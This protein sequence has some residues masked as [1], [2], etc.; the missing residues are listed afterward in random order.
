MA[1]GNIPQD[2]IGEKRSRFIGR[3]FEKDTFFKFFLFFILI[4]FL[5]AGYV[6]LQRYRSSK[7]ASVA[8]TAAAVSENTSAA[9]SGSDANSGSLLQ[10][11]TNTG[12]DTAASELTNANYK[13]ENFRVGEMTIGGDTEFL[14]QDS[15][16]PLEIGSIRS[17]AYNEKNKQEVNLVLSWKTNKLAKSDV[18]YSKGVG[19]Q[20]KKMSEDDFSFNHSMVIPGLDQASTYVY[21]ITSGDR[22]GDVVRSDA[23]VVYTGSKTAS[24]FDL[25]SGAIGDVFGWAVKK[26]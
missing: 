21:T 5:V 10:T 2:F 15:P 4:A 26:N 9:K 7:T 3:I 22:S 6:L 13:S 20:E 23:H 24:L 11:S 19:Q 12:S 1:N 16:A 14:T 25:I 17:E 18:N 8:Q